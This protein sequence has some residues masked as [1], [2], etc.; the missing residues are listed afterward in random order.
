[1]ETKSE[2]TFPDLKI[3]SYDTMVQHYTISKNGSQLIAVQH[4]NAYLFD[5]NEKKIL[6]SF[7]LFH[8]IKNSKP[9]FG[10]DCVAFRTDYGCFSIYRI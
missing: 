4:K 1:L 9:V 5:L 6:Y 8:T 10:Q 7:R 2:L 3:P